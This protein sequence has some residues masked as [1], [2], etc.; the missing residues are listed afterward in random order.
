[1]TALTSIAPQLAKMLP[2]LSSNIDGEVV[3]AA[4]AIDRLLRDAGRDW[5]DLVAAVLLPPAPAESGKSAI[6]WCLSRRHLLSPR[7][8]EFLESV[9]EQLRPLSTRQASWLND[10]VA[11]LGSRRAA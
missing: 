5:H 1:V 2:M 3:A 7:D 9:A 11:K 6:R 4:H 8:R 10:I